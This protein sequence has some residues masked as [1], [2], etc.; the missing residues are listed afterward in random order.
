MV[1]RIYKFIENNDEL[2][3]AFDIRRQVFIKEQ[4][5]PEEIE[6]DE[7]DVEALHMIVLEEGMPVATARLRFPEEGLAKIERMAVLGDFRGLGIGTE[8]VSFLIDEISERADVEQIVLHAQF[9]AVDFY[10]SCGFKITSATFLEAG[11][12]HVEMRKEI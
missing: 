12:E 9:R 2:Q 11:I 1:W 6:M 7:L 3:A 8:M 5:I 4:G 10:K